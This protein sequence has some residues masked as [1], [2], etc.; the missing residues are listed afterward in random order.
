[1]EHF[2]RVHWSEE[3]REF[4]ATC[5]TFPSLSWLDPSEALAL[6]GIKKLVADVEEDLR[7]EAECIARKQELLG[8]VAELERLIERVK[9]S[10][11]TRPSLEARLANARAELDEV[12]MPRR[13]C[14]QVPK[15]RIRRIK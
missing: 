2:F 13:R 4:V 3:D 1:M 14:Y 5:D 8:E 9:D 7:H 6:C 15:S 10:V 12:W 11:F